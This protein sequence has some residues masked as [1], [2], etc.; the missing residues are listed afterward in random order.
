MMSCKPNRLG[1]RAVRINRAFAIAFFCF[2]FIGSMPAQQTP[3]ERVSEIQQALRDAKLD[4]WLFY[5]F[6]KSDPLAYGTL[7]WKVKLFASRV[8]FYYVPAWG[9]RVK[10]VKSIENLKLEALPGKKLFF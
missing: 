7:K 3:A 8:C 10:F 5:D 1:V 6:R 2:T 9:E 4:G